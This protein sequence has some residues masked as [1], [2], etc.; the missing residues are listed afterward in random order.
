MKPVDVSL[1]QNVAHD[2]HFLVEEIRPR[3][4]SRGKFI[5]LQHYFCSEALLVPMKGLMPEPRT[6]SPKPQTIAFK[7]K[8]LGP[9]LKLKTQSHAGRAACEAS[10]F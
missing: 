5:R 3:S 10:C 6:P 7:I 1:S 9:T 4:S 2:T 8:G